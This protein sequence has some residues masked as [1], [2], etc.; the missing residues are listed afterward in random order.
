MNEPRDP[1]EAAAELPE[2]KVKVRK[3]NFPVVWAVP[4]VAAI[5]AG[6]LI[7]HRVHEYGPKITITF[8]DAGG[9]KSGQTP[10]KYRGVL[11]G[12]VTSLELDGNLQQ[13]LVKARLRRTGASIAREGSVFWIVR[14]EVGIG[15][16]TGLGTVMTGPQ[17]EVLPGGGQPKTEFVGL[18]NAPVAQERK[19]LNIVLRAA[20]MGSLKLGSPVTYRGI[21]VGAV[22]DSRLGPDATTVDIHVYIKRRYEKLVRNGSKFWDVSG[23]DVKAGLFRGLEINV[24][25]LRTVM[26]GGIAFATPDDPKDGPAKDGARFPLYD[27]PKKEWLEWAPKI[28]VPPEK[29]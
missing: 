26:A 16:I 2:A 22:Q 14:P 3:W 4:V 24:E 27:K 21:E 10:I 28:P 7:F 12:E 18:E 8:K 20:R 9:L 1:P 15:N 6:Y 19:G 29:S 17:I 25:S 23:I 11:V 5:V 13:V